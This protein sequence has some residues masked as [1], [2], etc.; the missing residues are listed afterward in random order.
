MAATAGKAARKKG[1][2]GGAVLAIFG[3]IALLVA[4][5]VLVPKLLVRTGAETGLEIGDSGYLLDK[6]AGWASGSINDMAANLGYMSEGGIP[7][8]NLEGIRA[9]S[10]GETAL[11]VAVIAVP[12]EMAAGM[13][14]GIE[15]GTPVPGLA[16]VGQAYDHTLGPAV[17]FDVTEMG[18]S[19]RL[20]MIAGEGVL[21]IAVVATD[22]GEVTEKDIS[23]YGAMV[24]S[25][26]PAGS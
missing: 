4:A 14:Q 2:S 26:R 21:V 10:K 20:T 13:V 7:G 17:E 16:P 9:F 22:A 1:L 5:V 23:D 15:S 18:A 3:A 24:E 6:P 25:L 8:T 11:A 19:G 12:P